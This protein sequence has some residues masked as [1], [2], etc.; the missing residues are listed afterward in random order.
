MESIKSAHVTTS[1]DRD[2]LFKEWLDNEAMGISKELAKIEKDEKIARKATRK[3]AKLNKKKVV[4]QLKKTQSSNL[5]E[6]ATT[7]T[8]E[9]ESTNNLQDHE[10]ISSNGETAGLV[11]SA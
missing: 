2:D 1:L 11:D 6:K 4:Q 3:A 8:N 7:K 9:G 10:K 5:E